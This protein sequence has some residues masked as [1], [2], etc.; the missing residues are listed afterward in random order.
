MNADI[1]WEEQGLQFLRCSSGLRSDFLD[2]SLIWS[3]GYFGR[4]ST[5]GKIY[6]CS[7]WLSLWFQTNIYIKFLYLFR[8]FFWITFTNRTSW[9]WIPFFFDKSFI[10][11]SGVFVLYKILSGD[12]KQLTLINMQNRKNQDKYLF[13]A[14]Y[15]MAGSG[16]WP[17]Q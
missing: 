5:S 3:W 14:L 4:E 8:N 1:I 10:Y 17:K 16:N 11:Q 15:N 2:E 12:L 6:H 7:K 13:T 9:R